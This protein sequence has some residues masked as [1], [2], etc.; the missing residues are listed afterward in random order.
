MEKFT[1]KYKDFLYESIE[2]RIKDKISE[3]YRSLKRGILDLLEDTVQNK[4]ELVNVQNFMNNY[5]KDPEKNVITGF[6]E[7]GDIFDFYFKYQSDIDEI[8]EKNDYFS[9]SPSEKNVF[10][11]YKFIIEGTKFSVKQCMELML[12]ELF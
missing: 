10:S 5:T 9:E 3:D 8:C 7:D 12:K 6:I 1:T 4:E 11:L 2:D